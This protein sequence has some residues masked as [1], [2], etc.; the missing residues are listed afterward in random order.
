MKNYIQTCELQP[1]DYFV[2]A[3]DKWG[4]YKSL[5]IHED[6]YSHSTHHWLGFAPYTF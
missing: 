1:D 3:A 2:G 5:Q 6:S 4:N